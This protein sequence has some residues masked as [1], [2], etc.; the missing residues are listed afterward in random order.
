M[1]TRLQPHPL[2]LRHPPPA[3][4][5]RRL[6]GGGQRDIVTIWTAATYTRLYSWMVNYQQA[7]VIQSKLLII[8]VCYTA[9]KTAV[10]VF[11]LN[12][13]WIDTHN[14]VWLFNSLLSLS[15]RTSSL[16]LCSCPSLSAGFIFSTWPLT[17]RVP[18]SACLFFQQPVD[19][20]TVAI[21]V[22]YSIQ[23]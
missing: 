17:K 13:I 18:V 2:A 11:C 5:R 7:M 6:W 4:S 14:S 16:S 21:L 15:T 10:V 9:V 22:W 20:I 3:T 19:W 1:T 23:I 8:V 12:P